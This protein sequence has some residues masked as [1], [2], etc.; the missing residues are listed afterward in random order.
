MVERNYGSLGVMVRPE[1]RRVEVSNKKSKATY[2]DQGL[3][4]R[5]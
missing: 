4:V 2:P 5:I 3:P 1:L